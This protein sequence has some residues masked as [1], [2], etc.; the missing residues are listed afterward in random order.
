MK[1]FHFEM[2]DTYGGETNYCW[3]K[4]YVIN[5][6][7]LQGAITKLAKYTG[8]RFRFDGVMYKSAKSCVAAYEV[9]Y[10]WGEEQLNDFID[11]AEEI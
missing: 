5:A 3:L 9:D 11:R 7:T 8:Y 2:T 6:N 1:Q 10:T 4:R